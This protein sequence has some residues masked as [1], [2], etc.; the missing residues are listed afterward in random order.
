[1]RK[2][3]A[4]HNNMQSRQF[5]VERVLAHQL[6]NEILQ[7]TSWREDAAGEKADASQSA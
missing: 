6:A 7:G 5:Y 2:Q 1:M 4:F 3:I